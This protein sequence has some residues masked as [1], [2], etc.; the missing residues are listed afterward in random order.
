[1]R[2]RILQAYLLRGLAASFAGVASLLLIVLVIGQVPTVLNRAVTREIAPELIGKVVALVTIANSPA[3]LPISLLLAIVLTLGRLGSDN[4]LTAMRAGGVSVLAVLVP[5]LLLALPLALVQGAVSLR[6]APQS[7]CAALKMRS[8]AARN[9]A[10]GTIR[11]GVFQGFGAGSTYFVGSVD[12]DGTLHDVF[13]KRGEGAAIELILAARG[14]LVPY[15]AEDRLQLRLSDGRRYEGIPGSGRFRILTFAEYEAW[16][17]L[18]S[19]VGKC[20]RPDSQTTASLFASREPA[21]RAELNWRLALPVSVLVLALLAV[22]M[23]RTR[24]RQGRYA[25]VPLALGVFFLY[26]FSMIGLTSLSTRNP[27][28]GAPLLWTL[29]VVMLAAA[30]AGIARQQGWWRARRR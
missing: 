25:R 8:Q 28:L 4:E 29:Q 27:A 18:P 22:P 9:I 6:V 1:M 26:F 16:F 24:P 13:V 19:E 15:A 5:V 14:R 21:M 20:E 23:S 30:L 11:P 10:L 3:V 17:A 12:P 7:Y 2:P